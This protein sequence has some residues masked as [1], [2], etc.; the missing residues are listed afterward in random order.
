MNTFLWVTFVV[1]LTAA[2]TALV[3][4]TLALLRALKS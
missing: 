2:L 3:V 4:A 1:C